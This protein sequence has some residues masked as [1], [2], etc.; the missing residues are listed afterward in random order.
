MERRQHLLSLVALPLTATLVGCETFERIGAI[1]AD[2]SR[3][4]G[5]S[6]GVTLGYSNGVKTAKVELNSPPVGEV[7][8]AHRKVEEIVMRHVKGVQKINVEIPSAKPSPP[9]NT[10]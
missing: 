3:E 9:P 1:R 4:L 10:E 6:C 2:V 5:V 7:T 8:D